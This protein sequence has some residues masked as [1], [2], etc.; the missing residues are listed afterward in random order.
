MTDTV[1][2][3]AD[4]NGTQIKG[5]IT[6]ITG[7]LQM[8]AGRIARNQDLERRGFA[9]R[10]AGQSQRAVGDA[11]QVINDCIKRQY[12]KSSPTKFWITG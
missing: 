12:A 3:G 1:I 5:T 7:S 6:S 9:R 2:K 8:R 11:Q 4:M 10:I